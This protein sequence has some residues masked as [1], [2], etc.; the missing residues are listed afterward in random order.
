M[1]KERID[2]DL[3]N[4]M[5]SGENFRRDVLRMV[6]SAI[7]NV[8][9]EK[10]KR[11]EGLADD[12]VIEILSRS[13]K[14]RK[15]SAEQYLKGS[16]EDLAEKEQKE[17][18]LLLTYLPE[19]LSEEEIKKAVIETIAQAGASSKADLGKV[20]GSVMKKFKG[21]ADGNLVRQIAETL[22]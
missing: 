19:Q 6:S 7:K 22:L 18:E 21:R 4:A 20:M 15:D 2:A 3:K 10:G 12:E 1:L 8:E 13:I 17:I 9:I 11:E 5:K 16:R 14:Q